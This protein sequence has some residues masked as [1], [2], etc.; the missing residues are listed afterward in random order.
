M[1]V[2]EENISKQFMP[3]NTYPS[4]NYPVNPGLSSFST[5]DSRSPSARGQASRERRVFR[6]RLPSSHTREGGYPDRISSNELSS[7]PFLTLPALSGKI[8]RREKGI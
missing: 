6:C 1:K 5:L 4:C 2:Q 3:N 8:D 7:Y